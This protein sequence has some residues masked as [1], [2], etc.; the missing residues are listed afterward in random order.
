MV[1]V[2]PI[3]CGRPKKGQMSWFEST[4]TK[5]HAFGLTQYDAVLFL[6][7]DAVYKESNKKMK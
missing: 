2:A 7:A 4:C 1:R 5:L 3:S 6:D